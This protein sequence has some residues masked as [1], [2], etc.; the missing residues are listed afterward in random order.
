MI[1]TIGDEE[2]ARLRLELERLRVEGDRLR[3]ELARRPRVSRE[4]SEATKRGVA[5]RDLLSAIENALG[6]EQQRFFSTYGTNAGDLQKL[7]LL[8]EDD[9]ARA[10]PLVDLEARW[11]ANAIRKLLV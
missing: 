1:S 11:Y 6:S 5:A 3:I 8:C 9:A 10:G 2:L 7:I 4:K